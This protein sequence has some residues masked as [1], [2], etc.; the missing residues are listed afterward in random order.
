MFPNF[1]MKRAMLPFA[2]AGS[3]GIPRLQRSRC[4]R[5]AAVPETRSTEADAANESGDRDAIRA[6]PAG[7]EIDATILPSAY[8]KRRLRTMW[9]GGS[10]RL[11][12]LGPV[13]ASWQQR[14]LQEIDR[15][16]PRC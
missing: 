5:T 13:D 6:A 2:R 11:I 4:G 1:N 16:L 12:R 7:A 15:R 9:A 10:E 14:P 8:Q 3:P